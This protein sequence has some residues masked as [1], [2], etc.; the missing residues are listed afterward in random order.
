MLPTGKQ[1]QSKNTIPSK[2]ENIIHRSV[3]ANDLQNLPRRELY[4][5]LWLWSDAV[6]DTGRHED[7]MAL[8]TGWR[9]LAKRTFGPTEGGEQ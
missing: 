6:S 4:L 7:A 8:V 9:A 2:L 5:L 1:Y 3:I